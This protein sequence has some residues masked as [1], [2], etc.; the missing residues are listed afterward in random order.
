MKKLLL[1]VIIFF[2]L[3]AAWVTP[4]CTKD[5]YEPEK[6]KDSIVYVI[7]YDTVKILSRDT[8]ILGQDSIHVGFTY[9]LTYNSDTS[10]SLPISAISTSL[11]VPSNATYNW[12]LQSGGAVILTQN[13]QS[14]FDYDINYLQNGNAILTMNLTCPTQARVYSVAK[15][16][17]IKLKSTY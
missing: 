5:I 1:P 4:S 16:F 15:T 10:L 12:I 7:K 17:L 6:V 3:A 8:V 13:N 2:S 11:N 9:A 14:Y